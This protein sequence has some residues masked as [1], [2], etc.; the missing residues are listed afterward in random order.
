MKKI[1]N[2]FICFNLLLFSQNIVA[3]DKAKIKEKKP[4][5]NIRELALPSELSTIGKKA[6]SIYYSP[7]V[8]DKVLMPVHFWGEIGNPGLHFIPLETTLVKGLSMAGG[9]RNEGILDEVKVTRK[10]EKELKTEYFDLTSGGDDSAHV[11]Q[12]QPGDTVFIKKSRFF[13]NRG[14]YTSLFGVVATVLSSIL[15]YQQVKE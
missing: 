11:Y 7:S 10:G 14:Y 2:L 12:L 15:I 5:L 3:N 6:G 13:E 9:P 1:I 8:K 4:S